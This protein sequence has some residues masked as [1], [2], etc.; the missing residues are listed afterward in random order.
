[1]SIINYIFSARAKLKLRTAGDSRDK[2]RGSWLE[3]PPT[4]ERGLCTS[5]LPT[6]MKADLFQTAP[7]RNFETSNKTKSNKTN[8]NLM[9]MA[10]KRVREMQVKNHNSKDTHSRLLEP[11]QWR[12]HTISL[13]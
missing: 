1:M 12:V 3:A 9:P 2:T 7:A 6:D 11:R 13:F 4:K 10:E 8:K 5:P